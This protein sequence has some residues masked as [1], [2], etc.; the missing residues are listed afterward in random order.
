LGSWE[1]RYKGTSIWMPS[2]DANLRIYEESQET[3]GKQAMNRE[4][5]NKLDGL[6]I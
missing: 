6:Y 1:L 4:V 5:F 2:R 3:I